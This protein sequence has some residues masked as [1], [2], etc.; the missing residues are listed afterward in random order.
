VGVSTVTVALRLRSVE[1]LFRQPDLD[2]FSEWYQPYSDQP[3]IA[4][5]EACVGDQLHH[6]DLVIELPQDAVEPA[7]KDKVKAA[8][9]R[10]CDARLTQVSEESGRNNGRG[11]LMLAFALVVVSIF[12]FLAHRLDNAGYETLSV[13]AEGLSIAAWLLLWHPLDALVFNRWDLRLDRRV[14]ATIRHATVVHIKEIDA[15]Q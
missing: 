8:L 4:Y 2:P 10:Y 12:L 15:P 14:L 1:D 13:F 6:L 7:L 11:W 9:E 3:A 5:V